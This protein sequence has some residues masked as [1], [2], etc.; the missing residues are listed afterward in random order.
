MQRE[1]QNDRKPPAKSKIVFFVTDNIN[2][3][4]EVRR[5]LAEYK[6]PIGMLRVKTPEIQSEDL[7][8]IAQRSVNDAFARCK[9][10]IIV[11][12]AGLFIE[13]LNG[14]PG[15]YSAYVYK[16]IGNNGLLKLLEKKKERKAEF[17]SI[18]AYRDNN[19][20]IPISFEGSVH[21]EITL[22]EQ[23]KNK[24]SGFGFDPIFK[25]DHFNKSFAEMNIEEKNNFSHRAKAIHKFAHWYQNIETKDKNT[26]D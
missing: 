19:S 24:K 25:P 21:G 8:K 2:K 1:K 14:F 20:E 11:E 15:P 22:K 9:L 4:N 17:K 23:K 6:V 7:E 5:I 12:D 16:T 18:I 10:P 3:F 13:K 26:I